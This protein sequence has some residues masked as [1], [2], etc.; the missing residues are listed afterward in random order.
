MIPR[1]SDIF[2]QKLNEI[3]SRVPVR[4]FRS[5]E[6]IPFQEYLEIAKDKLEETALPKTATDHSIDI[7]RA[8]KSLAASTAFIPADKARLMIMVNDNI[9]KAS[10]KYHIDAELLRAVVKQESNFNPY[11]ISSSGAQ[12]LMQ[13]MPDTADSL[14]VENPWDIMQNI[15]GGAR[16]LKDQLIAFNGNLRLALAAYNAG[17]ENVVKYNGIPPFDETR[18]YVDKVLQYYFQYS[19][20]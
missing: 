5:S 4:I 13:L 10:E 1:V 20:G 8:Q 19:E 9:K 7:E 17:P 18:N 3:Q 15:D 6:S 11:A 16:Y 14:G 12:G 2:Q